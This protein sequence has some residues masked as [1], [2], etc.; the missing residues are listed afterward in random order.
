MFLVEIWITTPG[1]IQNTLSGLGDSILSI[2]KRS[3]RDRKSTLSKI[4][5]ELLFRLFDNF[6]KTRNSYAPT[7]YK[8]LTFLLV[9]LYWVTEMRETMIR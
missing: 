3:S 1:F 6:I 7:V 9:E 4:A 5:I 8:S 2:L